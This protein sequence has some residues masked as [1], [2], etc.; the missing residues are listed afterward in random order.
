MHSDTM[1]L[2]YKTHRPLK[3]DPKKGDLEICACLSDIEVAFE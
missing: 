1:R 3:G 2:A